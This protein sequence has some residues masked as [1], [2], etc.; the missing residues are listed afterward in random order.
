MCEN[1]HLEFAHD[2]RDLIL[3]SLI[4]H[5]PPAQ[6]YLVPNEDD[7]DLVS[8]HIFAHKPLDPR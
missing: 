3:Q 5:L 8:E 6:V 7:R 1:T 4:R 2:G